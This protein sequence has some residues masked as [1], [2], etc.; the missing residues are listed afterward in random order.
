[1]VLRATNMDD[2]MT[3][4]EMVARSDANCY[5]AWRLTAATA[6]DGEAWQGDGIVVA[7]TGASV[8]WLNPVF[9]TRSMSSR[10]HALRRAVEYF[11]R[12][13]LPFIVRVREGLGEES[14][15]A[16]EAIGL[17][18]R[19]TLPG[20]VLAPLSAVEDKPPPV[21]IRVVEDA[22]GFAPYVNIMAESFH[23]DPGMTA[24]MMTPRLLDIADSRWYL[25]HVDGRPVGAAALIMTHRVAGVHYVGALEAYRHRGVGEAMTRHAVREGA[26]AGCLFSSL[27]ASEMGRPVYERIGFRTITGYKTFVRPERP[28]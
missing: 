13:G 24:R 5:E 23:L 18:Y 7:A 3:E 17:P 25:G 27:Q 2:E 15:R 20:M 14:E 28:E 21:E 6:D 4:A 26:A 11:D 16:C 8:G 19:D 9:V 22:A 12:R 1:M 10:G